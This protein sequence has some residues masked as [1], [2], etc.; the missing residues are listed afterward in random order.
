M[1]ADHQTSER[2]YASL[3]AEILRGAIAGHLQIPALAARHGTSATPVREAILRLVGERLLTLRAG[4]GFATV[5]RD[6]FEIRALYEL[7]LRLALLA[8]NW[9][10]D[11]DDAPL[12]PHGA[13]SGLDPPIDRLFSL[14]AG[15]T[16]NVHLA[17]VTSSVN[18]QLHRVRC[19]EKEEFSGLSREF[20]A[21]DALVRTKAFPRLGAALRAYHRRRIKIADRIARRIQLD[22]LLV[23][24]SR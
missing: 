10:R 3:K 13:S 19:A 17:A 18:D 16:G 24:P 6:E 22:D 21:L 11:C 4:G 23:L 14:L 15:R 7:N 8:A 9:G 1:V 20:G 5:I 2:V 12:T